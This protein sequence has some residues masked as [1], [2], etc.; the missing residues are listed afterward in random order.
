M[1]EDYLR[2]LEVQRRYSG[3]TVRLYRESLERFASYIRRTGGD[4]ERLADYLTAGVIR[5]WEVD[6]MDREK[7]LPK[8][9]SLHMSA[10][11]G[12]CR[13]LVR[14]GG[15]KDNP[16]AKVRRPRIP[17]RL[18]AFF[19]D[20]ALEQWLSSTAA[21][22]G[23]DNLA[24]LRSYAPE[25]F[26]KDGT[27]RRLYRERLSRTVVST[28][29]ATGLRRS[30][31]IGLR[32]SSV[33]FRRRSLSVRGKGDKMREIPLVPSICQE[34]SLYLQAVEVL[35]G[36]ARSASEP[37]FV[38]LKG[39]ALYPMAVERMVSEELG[40]RQ[41]LPGRKSPHVLRHSLATELLNRGADLF[42]IKEM[43]GHASLA[44]TQVYTHN[45][46][47]KLKSVYA[48]AHPRALKK[49]TEENK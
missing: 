20:E 7:L 11:S 28:L 12:W 4:P 43:L 37:L 38:T 31:L 24:L 36:R 49:D 26:R 32:V 46:I 30:E 23:E 48:S 17:K 40:G 9:V 6:M 3:R 25:D 21:R 22:V 47:E 1:F 2:Y 42:A 19:R 5:G 33:D 16:A 18:P 10:L 39:G 35:T 34:L 27:A 15:L 41:D 8:T 44:A 29:Y 13:F 45:T 14:E